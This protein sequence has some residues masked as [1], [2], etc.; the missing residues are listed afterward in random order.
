MKDK[1]YSTA[2]MN[3]ALW[4]MD[5]RVT[6]YRLEMFTDDVRDPCGEIFTDETH[7]P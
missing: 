7:L 2:Y 6:L 1:L 4:S 5:R 3:A